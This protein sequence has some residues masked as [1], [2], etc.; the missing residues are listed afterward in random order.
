MQE[1]IVKLSLLCLLYLNFGLQAPVHAQY[2][3]FTSNRKKVSIPFHLVRDLVIVQL[4][5]NDK[6]P[7]NFIMDTG[8]GIM[9]ITDPKLIDSVNIIDKRTLKIGGFGEKDAYE[10]LI[11]T[12]LKVDIQELTSFNVP[13]AILKTEHFGLSNF[14][15]MPIHGLLGYEFFC[16][17][18]VKV[19]FSDSTITAFRPKD[20]HL[21]A[22][23]EAIP[24][25]IENNKPFLETNVSFPCGTVK[26]C[27]LIIDLGAG[28]P[29]SLENLVAS[30]ELPK[31]AIPA[32]L[33]IGF[34]G[35]ISGYLSRITKVE[36]GKYSIKNLITSFPDYDTLKSKGCVKRDG[37]LGI[38]LLKKFI[39]VFDY[40]DKVMYLKPGANFYEPIEH[41]MSGLEYYAGGDDY[42]R[43]FISRVEPGSA[44]D[45]IGLEQDD[46]LVEI[47]FKPTAKMS[48]EE[49]DNL[50]KSQDERSLLLGIC[51]DKKYDLMVM[52][53]KRRI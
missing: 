7:F 1:R 32:H 2:F 47:N 17:L 51:H 11:T 3:D 34:N 22:K 12:P 46:E 10:A 26:K 27:K 23:G 18:A 15:G 30:A 29:L 53:L 28:H 25:T 52:K 48:L 36:L 43:I 38:G 44:G 50:F 4:K 45:A 14:A 6:G 37:N 24:I 19:N 16:N 49:I 41:D 42:K 13:A 8:V 9:I 39:V 31:K 33:G 40:A 5:I 21:F 20:K 35:P